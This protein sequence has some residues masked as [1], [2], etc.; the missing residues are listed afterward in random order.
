MLAPVER[1]PDPAAFDAV[2]LGSAVYAGG[3]LQPACRY[4][5]AVAPE[6]RARPTWLFSSGITGGPTPFPQRGDDG[7]WI[8][9]SIGALGHQVFPGRVERRVLSAAE[10]HAWGA[11]PGMAG[12][13]R[14]WPAVRAWAGEIATELAA[15]QAAPMA[16]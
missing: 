15:R 3:W 8:G 5:G 7:R 4:V 2:V 1:G 12:D 16:G 14:D 11:G 10:R 13:F 6:L 9:D